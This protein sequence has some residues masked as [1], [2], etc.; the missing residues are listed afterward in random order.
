MVRSHAWD[1]RG[2]DRSIMGRGYIRDVWMEETR[3][4]TSRGPCQDVGTQYSTLRIF[5]IIWIIGKKANKNMKEK[6]EWIDNRL[7]I[8]HHLSLRIDP[9]RKH[10][11]SVFLSPPP[12]SINQF[13]PAAP[14]FPHSLFH[15]KIQPVNGA[16]SSS[17][18]VPHQSCSGPSIEVIMLIPIDTATKEGHWL[19]IHRF[20]LR[21]EQGSKEVK[22]GDLQ[23]RPARDSRVSSPRSTQD[24]IVFSIE[25][26]R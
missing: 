7:E 1:C 9:T 26:V 23:S 18:D 13:S 2:F 20:F 8:N 16:R 14:G 21:I 4:N 22:G 19:V 10:F 15:I 6:K 11:C 3:C 24:D 12:Q 25:E 5:M 17:S